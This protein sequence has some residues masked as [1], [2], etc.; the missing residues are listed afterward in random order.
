MKLHIKLHK[1]RIIQIVL[2]VIIVILIGYGLSANKNENENENETDMTFELNPPVAEEEAD[3]EVTDETITVPKVETATATETTAVTTTTTTSTSSGGCYPSLSARKDSKFNAIVL[4]WTTCSNDDFQFY[5]L[6]K[7]Q[8]NPYP[9]YP[10]D[11][12]VSSSSNPGTA[13]YIDKTVARAM[14]Y[15]YRVCVVQRLNK[16]TCGNAVSITY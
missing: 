14:T 9:A 6:V 15:Y 11:S 5:K 4:N 10:S 3:E 16:V 7:S 13:N 8:T 1:D 2:G 12:V